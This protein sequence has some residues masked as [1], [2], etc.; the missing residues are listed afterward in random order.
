MNQ[1]ENKGVRNRVSVF[2]TASL[3]LAEYALAESD[4]KEFGLNIP[5]NVATGVS[6]TI[7]SLSVCTTAYVCV[8]LFYSS[9]GFL[10]S[11][12]WVVFKFSFS[13]SEYFILCKVPQQ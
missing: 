6:E 12:F 8:R 1:A 7:P 11:L 5:V 9:T 4:G 2:G 13:E 10:M 3:N